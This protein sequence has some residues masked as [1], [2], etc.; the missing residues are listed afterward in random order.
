VKN[1][2][3]IKLFTSEN[4]S[5]AFFLSNIR[6]IW[7]MYKLKKAED[8]NLFMKNDKEQQLRADRFNLTLKAKESQH[9]GF[10]LHKNDIN[11]VDE[12]HLFE[13]QGDRRMKYMN[14]FFSVSEQFMMNVRSEIGTRQDIS[15]HEDQRS[16]IRIDARKRPELTDDTFVS[17]REKFQRLSRKNK[18]L[19][20]YFLSPENRVA[21]QMKGLRSTKGSLV[22]REQFEDIQFRP[23]TEKGHRRVMS[24]GL[25]TSKQS[26]AVPSKVLKGFGISVRTLY[27][28]HTPVNFSNFSSANT[29]ANEYAE[30]S[31]SWL[32]GHKDMKMAHLLDQKTKVSKVRKIETIMKRLGKA[33]QN[34]N[35]L[36]FKNL[37]KEEKQLHKEL[38]ELDKNQRQKEIMRKRFNVFRANKR[39]SLAKLDR[40]FTLTFAQHKNVIAKHASMGEKR[41]REN[42]Y[43]EKNAKIRTNSNV[44]N[45]KQLS[46]VSMTSYRSIMTPHKNPVIAKK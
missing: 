26:T 34:R 9:E 39:K 41:R 25:D 1:K 31:K 14:V 11:K 16:I 37:I 36:I 23:E 13:I 33:E 10:I 27:G 8:L 5:D 24:S 45:L 30:T 28:K 44:K 20:R 19:D 6:E 42:E 12:K 35:V 18:D 15:V 29:P 43:L 40:E 3:F 46:N 32:A 38:L 21:T 22:S 17:D 7:K 4:L 2:S